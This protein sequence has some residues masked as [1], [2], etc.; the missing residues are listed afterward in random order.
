MP[1]T[2]GSVGDIISIS[3]IV[4]DLVQAL[5][6]SRGSA[7]EYQD[8]IRE[9]WAL[10]RVLLEVEQVSRNSEQTNGLYAL[11][12]TTKRA[13]DECR[14]CIENFLEK[15]KK[16]EKSLGGLASGHTLRGVPM[17]IR[18]RLTQSD[19]L[20]KFRT[21]INAH[22]SSLSMLLIAVNLNV[23][24]LNA[25]KLREAH[26]AT[27]ELQKNAVQ[28]QNGLLEVLQSGVDR[29]TE[30][31]KSHTKLIKHV[32]KLDWLRNLASDLKGLARKIL[33]VNLAT[34]RMVADLRASLPSHLDRCL[35]QELFLLEDAIGREAPVHLQF[36]NSWDALYA[37]LEAR[38]Q[39]LQGYNKVKRKEFVLQERATRRDI[40]HAGSWEGSFLPG[41]R[42]DMSITFTEIRQNVELACPR[43]QTTNRNCSGQSTQCAACGMWFTRVIE[44]CD[45][46]PLDILNPVSRTARTATAIKFNNP[47]IRIDRGA[48][49]PGPLERPVPDPKSHIQPELASWAEKRP[50]ED[51]EAVMQEEISSFKRV[52]M[53]SRQ[54]RENNGNP[55][56]DGAPL[57]P[58]AADQEP[59]ENASY[60]TEDAKIASSDTPSPP[61]SQ[62]PL[63][64]Q[65]R[66]NNETEEVVEKDELSSPLSTGSMDVNFGSTSNYI[67]ENG[68]RYHNYTAC[69][70]MRQEFP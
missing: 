34:F 49:T 28:K 38:F 36:I 61:N 62:V 52:R 37:V 42:V 23:A 7:A 59:N 29:N 11:W 33:F 21:A 70:M 65:G 17:K 45:P 22:C 56:T 50:L 47:T 8:L 68:R 10:D 18:W 25:K 51:I 4:K 32:M 46:D 30:V 26:T 35:I 40:S 64:R 39:N 16:Y 27:E 60:P 2:F 9:L 58:M 54:F 20:E 24:Q 53:I 14:Q 44:L 63:P 57:S 5:D 12:V 31:I 1:I 66:S 15:I 19:E 43:C 67:W 41:Q 3:L 13:T 69:Q 6:D 55:K 48:T